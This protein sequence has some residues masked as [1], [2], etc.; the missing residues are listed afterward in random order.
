MS[1]NQNSIKQRYKNNTNTL[2]TAKKSRLDS[3]QFE[4]NVRKPNQSWK[5]WIKKLSE[6]KAHHGNCDVPQRYSRD[7][8]L[9][10]FV[11]NLRGEYRK[12][13]RGK[14][15]SLNPK[16]IK[17]LEDMGFRWSV[18]SGK[19]EMIAWEE[20]VRQLK[21]YK[22]KFGNCNVPKEW[23]DNVGLGDWVETL[24]HVSRVIL[25]IVYC[26]IIFNSSHD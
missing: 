16:T 3:I 17:M 1:C 18:A 4:W 24:R 7:R 2:S 19:V 23:S 5:H 25:L 9:G 20:R 12:Y 10:A 26:G 15:S 14:N 8:A 13:T 22:E 6:Y 11:S 21:E